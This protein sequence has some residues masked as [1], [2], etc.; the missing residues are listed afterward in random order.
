MR[1]Q[2]PLLDSTKIKDFQRCPRYFFFKHVLGWNPELTAHDLVFGIA[3]HEAKEHLLL[4]ASNMEEELLPALEKFS[5]SYREHFTEETDQSFFPKSPANAAVALKKWVKEYQREFKNQKVLLTEIGGEVPISKDANLYFKIDAIVENEK[6]ICALDH[7]TTKM[8]SNVWRK[9]FEL[10]FQG[11]AYT[12]ALYFLYPPK[13]VYGFIIDGTVFKKACENLQVP[14]PKTFEMMQ[15]WVWQAQ[16]TVNT[17]KWNYSQLE[18]TS[19]TD[20]ILPC[21]AKNP[22]GCMKY[23]R[24]CPFHSFCSAW[25]N[26]LGRKIPPGFV[27]SFWDPRETVKDSKWTLTESGLEKTPKETLCD[28]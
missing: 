20:K 25:S 6:G 4:N 18:K 3:W 27:E 13:D 28:E 15:D 5:A 17:L 7:K 24:V 1:S 22:S 8:N 10:D 12:H 11:F 9:Q 21:F 26:P 2:F 14:V 23:N 16:H 19:P